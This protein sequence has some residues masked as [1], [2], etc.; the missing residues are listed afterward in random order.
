LGNKRLDRPSDP[1][2][3]TGQ[4]NDPLFFSELQRITR[5]EIPRSPISGIVIYGAGR[6]FSSGAVLED[7]IESV[8]SSPGVDHVPRSHGSGL[9]LE[10]LKSFMFF[11]ELEIPVIAAIKGVCLGSALELAL[12]CH[13]RICGR[14]SVL[15]LPEAGFGLIPGCGGIQK[16]NAL[17]GRSRALELIL[18]GASFTAEQAL[19]WKIIDRI[20]PKKIAVDSAIELIKSFGDN[21]DRRRIKNHRDRLP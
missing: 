15:G 1:E 7:L 12:F 8:T 3:P 6:H 16:I 18:S 21:N 20:V 19:E 11:E 17:A 2:R 4:R 10:N 13:Y 9:A 14:G 5:E